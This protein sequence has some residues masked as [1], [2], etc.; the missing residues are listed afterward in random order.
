VTHP[1]PDL[2]RLDAKLLVAV[3][4]DARR[5]AEDLSALVGLS[6]TACLRRL[7]R[8]RAAGVIEGEVALLAP[9]ALGLGT[10]ML[11]AVTLERDRADAIARFRGMARRTPEI[12]QAWYVAGE[13]DFVLLV[14][15]RDVAAYEAF[16]RDVF[17][18]NADIKGFRTTLILDRVKAGSALP[19]DPADYPA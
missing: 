6:P 11:V 3:Q 1:S 9:T 18:T 7:K 12:V 19:L 5:T 16:T 17:Y 2:D 14:A 8:L 15:C 4:E 13:A 10:L